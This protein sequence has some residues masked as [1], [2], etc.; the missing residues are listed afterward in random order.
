MEIMIVIV[1][2]VSLFIGPWAIKRMSRSLGQ[3]V[4]E[5]RKMLPEDDDA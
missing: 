3:T 1:I 4:G 5:I 2:A